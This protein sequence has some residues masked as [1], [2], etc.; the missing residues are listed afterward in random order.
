[1]KRGDVYTLGLE[2][3]T[4]P[5]RHGH[6]VVVVSATDFNRASRLAVV[7]PIIGDVGEPLSGFT[8]QLGGTRSPGIVR[9]DLPRVIDLHTAKAR[10]LGTLTAALIEEVMARL[11]ALFE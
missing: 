4:N 1:M 6:R 3:H 5:G 8:V 2:K 7:V 11:T 9:C 10:R